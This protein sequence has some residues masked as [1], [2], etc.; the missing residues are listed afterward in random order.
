MFVAAVRYTNVHSWPLPCFSFTASRS[1]GV[2]RPLLEFVDL[3]AQTPC[4][5][6]VATVVLSR[7]HMMSLSQG[8]Q[9]GWV[10]AVCNTLRSGLPKVAVLHPAR[11]PLE[12]SAMEEQLRSQ[13]NME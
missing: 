5:Q 13:L 1:D 7:M 6:P 8:S 11:T 9:Q 3:W 12:A 4:G 2:Q 10:R